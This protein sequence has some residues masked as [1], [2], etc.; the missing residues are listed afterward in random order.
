MKAPPFARV[1][2]TLNLKGGVGKTHSTWLLSAVAQERELR[3]LLVD[4]DTQG[5]LT[6]SFLTA[7]SAVPGVEL[8]FDP[9]AD[10]DV[11]ELI[12]RTPFS[13]IDLIPSGPA[14]A[15]FDLSDQSAWERAD[16][17]FSLLDAV[18]DLRGSYDLILFDCP[19]R[20][21]LVSFAALC[22]SDGVMIPLEAADWGAQGILQV[23]QAVEYVR[24]RY[25]PPLQLVGYLV[26]RFKRARA[27]QNSYLAQL[28]RHFGAEAFDTVIPDLAQFEKSVTDR[29]P[30]TLHA[31][32]S[33][34]S[35]IARRYFD[36]VL[37]RTARHAGR[38][39]RSRRPRVLDA[40]AAGAA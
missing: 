39:D 17:Q 1:L 36:E 23:A 12:R 27:Y 31:P 20:L 25:N 24:S 33:E 15:R 28:R 38:R 37:A 14:L 21:S 32:R 29:L 8:L 34:E 7:E 30:I 16:L 35:D 26:S 19:P 2:T 4:M 11:H 10:G 3:T 9:A 13:H 18:A 40:A 6:S 22:A 5:N